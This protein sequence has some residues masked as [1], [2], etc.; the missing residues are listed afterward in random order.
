MEG[1]TGEGRK[2]GHHLGSYLRT[3]KTGVVSPWIVLCTLEMVAAT[4][5]PPFLSTASAAVGQAKGS[6]IGIGVH[7]VLAM[8]TGTSGCPLP[9]SRC[10][11]PGTCC[12]SNGLEDPFL[13]KSKSFRKKICPASELCGPSF[14]AFSHAN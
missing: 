10:Q 4:V 8:T 13:K 12:P 2:M 1:V 9:C 7:R 6:G 3:L 11:Q 14:E 5:P